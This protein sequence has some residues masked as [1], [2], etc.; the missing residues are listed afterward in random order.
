MRVAPSL[1]LAAAYRRRVHECV[2]KRTDL[3]AGH[4]LRGVTAFRPSLASIC[5]ICHYGGS[6]TI[7]EVAGRDRSR[8]Q[9]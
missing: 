2:V 7:A 3:E 5:S 9:V 4:D 8:G 6:T 1:L